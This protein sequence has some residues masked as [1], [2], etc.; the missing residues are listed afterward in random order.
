MKINFTKNEYRSLLNLI[1]IGDWVM[2]SADIEFTPEQTKHKKLIQK[3]YSHY[4]EM[5]C[6]DAI[7]RSKINEDYVESREC[8]ELLR[9]KYLDRYD[10]NTFWDM[11]VDRLAIRDYER[12]PV[13]QN[14]ETREERIRRSSAIQD[15]VI[16]YSNEFELHGIERLEVVKDKNFPLH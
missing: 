10:E 6:D 13:I 11:L 16:T 14:P 15:I 1:S 3:I 5:N 7:E 4:K 12:S 2:C 9:D 8:E